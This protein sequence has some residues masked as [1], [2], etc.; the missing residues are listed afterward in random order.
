MPATCSAYREHFTG[1]PAEKLCGLSGTPA[2]DSQ[3]SVFGLSGTSRCNPQP[4]HTAYQE[5]ITQ[6]VSGSAFRQDKAAK[7]IIS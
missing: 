5:R 6:S 7:R 4:C 3:I 2:R 1:K